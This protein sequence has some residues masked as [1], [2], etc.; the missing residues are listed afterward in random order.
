ML[1]VCRS[2]RSCNRLGFGRPAATFYTRAIRRSSYHLPGGP[3]SL[4]HDLGHPLLS[5]LLSSP[6]HLL[7]HFCAA[8]DLGTATQSP[9]SGTTFK[10]YVKDQNLVSCNRSYHMEVISISTT[11]ESSRARSRTP[12]HNFRSHDLTTSICGT[13]FKLPL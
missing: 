7:P 3:I 4:K 12:S 6:G 8:I 11:L 5:S 9:G 1:R 2:R 10:K 13:D